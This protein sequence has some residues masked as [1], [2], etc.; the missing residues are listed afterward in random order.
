M[1]VD[2]SDP[3]MRLTDP[4]TGETTKDYLFVAALPCSQYSHV[5]ATL[6]MRQNTWLLCHVRACEFLGG[7]AARCVCGNLKTGVTSHPREDGVVLN[8]AYEALGRHYTCAIM[9]TG[10]RKPK[11][12][13]SVEGTVGKIATAVI[14]KL[15][16]QEFATLSELNEAIAEK[17]A[18]F[19]AA[20]FRKRDGSR[21]AVFEEVES[22]TYAVVA[23]L[24]FPRADIAGITYEGRPISRDLV[25]QLG[26]SRFV[27]N[28]TD[29]VPEGF[30]GTGKSHLTCALAKQACKNGIRRPTCACPTCS[31]TARS[32]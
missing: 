21:K 25:N 8:E 27:A 23:K 14:A 5:E 10:M 30:T 2:W 26:A 29:V 22:A 20:P 7:V 15:R 3:T 17:V 6:D 13:A 1:E 24:R 16:N 4:F 18:E 28:A 12:K 11:Q 19:N 32:A 31:R 9:P